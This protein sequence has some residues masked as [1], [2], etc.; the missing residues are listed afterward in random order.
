MEA[1]ERHL[2]EY[3]QCWEEVNNQQRKEQ[4]AV[5]GDLGSSRSFVIIVESQDIAIIWKCISSSPKWGCEH[6]QGSHKDKM[7]EACGNTV[8][9][10]GVHVLYYSPHS[11]CHERE[12]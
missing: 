9:E 2:T 12:K 5:V 4:H 8:R 10:T 6:L 7:R 3:S 11:C 1:E